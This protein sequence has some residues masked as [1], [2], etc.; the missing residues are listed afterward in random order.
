MCTPW[1]LELLL[2]LPPHFPGLWLLVDEKQMMLQAF[3]FLSL[4]CVHF[5]LSKTHGDLMLLSLMCQVITL[6]S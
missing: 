3:P 2:T 5:S 1:E 4:M 6:S